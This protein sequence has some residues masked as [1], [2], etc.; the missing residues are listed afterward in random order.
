MQADAVTATAST[1]PPCPRC[2]DPHI[3]PGRSSKALLSALGALA[4]GLQGWLRRSTAAAAGAQLGRLLGSV[5]GPV[6]Q[7]AGLAG[8]AMLGALVGAATGLALGNSLGHLVDRNIMGSYRCLRCGHRFNADAL[9]D[10]SAA[11]L[12]WATRPPAETTDADDLGA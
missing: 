12:R 2:G 8:G 4:G 10:G 7:T 5:A 1:A 11:D 9:V 3:V 6:G